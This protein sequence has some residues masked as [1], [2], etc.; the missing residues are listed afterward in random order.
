MRNPEH[1]NITGA[2]NFTTAT[3]GAWQTITANAK[4]LQ[5]VITPDTDC[6]IEVVLSGL[7]DHTNT[8]A[9]VFLGIDINGANVKH[10]LCVNPG[11]GIYHAAT[12]LY[13]F[14]ATAGTTYTITGKTLTSTAGTVTVNQSVEA[15]ELYIKAFKKP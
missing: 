14:A 8:T 12:V 3:T 4:T 2:S 13:E 5:I 6:R 15:T 10:A 1:A 9:G 11:V 7:I